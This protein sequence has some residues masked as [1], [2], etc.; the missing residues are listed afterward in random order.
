MFRLVFLFEPLFVCCRMSTL[1]GD[2]FLLLTQLGSGHIGNPRNDVH[3]ILPRVTRSCPLWSLSKE[4]R[5]D[6]IRA[7]VNYEKN[8][9]CGSWLVVRT[10]RA[11]I[12][13]V[14]LST[15]T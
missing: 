9:S 11:R 15:P 3:I 5:S 12:P 4:D 1:F 8:R 13:D 2:S 14:P 10:R 6:S 7:T